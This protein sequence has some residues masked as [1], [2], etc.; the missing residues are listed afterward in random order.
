MEGAQV[1]ALAGL[2]KIK[3][4]A[5]DLSGRTENAWVQDIFEEVHD[6]VEEQEAAVAGLRAMGGGC[7]CK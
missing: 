5:V 7:G 2:A 3:A 4:L 6:W 1:E